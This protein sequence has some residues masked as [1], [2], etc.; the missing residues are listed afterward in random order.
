MLDWILARLEEPSTWAAGGIGSALIHQSLSGPL[1]DAVTNAA[2]WICV[3]LAIVLKEKGK[4]NAQIPTSKP[5]DPPAGRV[6]TK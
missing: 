3:A 6:Q 2:A 5:A 4:V 1:A